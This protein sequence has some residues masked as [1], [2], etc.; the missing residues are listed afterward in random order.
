MNI[1]LLTEKY[2]PDL[3]GLP[4]S[5][6]R[7]AAG[8]LEAGHHVHVIT[9]SSQTASDQVQHSIEAGLHICRISS[10]QRNDDTLANWFDA[11]VGLHEDYHFDVLHGYYAVTAGFLA[12]Y[13][14][15]YL[16]IPSVV[17]V[18]G[19]DIERAVFHP[20]KAGHVLWS[21]QNSTAVTAASADL[22][23]KVTALAPQQSV[24][25][26]HNAVDAGV[27]SPA[28]YDPEMVMAIEEIG[29]DLP[30][31]GFVGEAR[32][33]K[34]IGVLLSAYTKVYEQLPC[35][36]LM[37]GS[38]RKDTQPMMEVYRARHPELP[39]STLPY[40]D[41]P[42]LPAAYPFLDVYVLPSLREGLPNSLLEAMATAC[43][44]VAS[45]VGGIPDAIQ[46]GQNGLLV[47]P[48][49]VDALAEALL[50]LL[51]NAELRQQL[52][53]AARETAVRAFRPETELERNVALYRRLTDR[54][55]I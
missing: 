1:C 24:E 52:G 6:G 37:L 35:R 4:V 32:I 49:D 21:L 7:L 51:R 26:I 3:G 15:R 17:S 14:A 39:L 47:A 11:I 45:D 33:Q 27:F 31:I 44:I 41:Y 54:R 53:E 48:G 22:A 5:T 29:N 36:L 23:R 19:N 43:A 28:A 18:R 46:H 30:V 25:L 8:L 40:I 10:L 2:A 16:H 9:T 12:A 42:R 55:V 13:V 38:V 34:G 50:A 20:G